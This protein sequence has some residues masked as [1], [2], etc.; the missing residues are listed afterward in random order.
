MMRHDYHAMGNQL[1]RCPIRINE[2]WPAR[3]LAAISVLV[4][5]NGGMV[6]PFIGHL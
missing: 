5:S 3:M 2:I 6:G 1:Q 4:L